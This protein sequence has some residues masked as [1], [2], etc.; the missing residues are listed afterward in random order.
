MQVYHPPRRHGEWPELAGRYQ[1]G[2]LV[3]HAPSRDLFHALDDYLKNR[4]ERFKAMF[5]RFDADGTGALD[6]AQ[7]RRFVS[8]LL[9][10]SS[11]AEMRYFQV[12][13]DVDG[14]NLVTYQEMVEV[15][16][17]C[18]ATGSEMR[19]PFDGANLPEPLR[20]LAAHVQRDPHGTKRAFDACDSHR[21]G[22]AL[23]SHDV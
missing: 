14:D 8:T 12:M 11:P 20:R 4:G 1:S 15:V 13:L 18:R 6:D 9:P 22:R 19:A 2:D 5:D 21:D 3:P 17:E 10:E 7:L 23:Y 16:K